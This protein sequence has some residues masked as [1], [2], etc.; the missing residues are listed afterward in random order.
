[1]H[2]RTRA[3]IFGALMPRRSRR[4]IPLV[5]TLLLAVLAGCTHNIGDP[6][7]TN[8]DCSP[9]GDRFCDTSAIGG[10]CTIEGCDINT[11]PDNEPCVRFFT[12]FT[13]DADR[14]GPTHPCARADER[15]ID[16]PMSTSA[17]F[18][19]HCAPESTERRWCQH[20][21]SNDGDCRTGFECRST[22]NG[23]TM[24]A[25]VLPG[26]FSVPTLNNPTGDPAS[27]C[28]QAS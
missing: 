17:D 8:V 18:T 27:F 5:A 25:P 6:C 2:A 16:D 9:A 21:C 13:D 3:S 4:E 7:G 24:S 1:M 20:R 11:C 15:C 26:A 14:C 23:G 19:G 10:Y 22:F 12:P 28:V